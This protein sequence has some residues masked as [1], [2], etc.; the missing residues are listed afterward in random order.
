MRT[1]GG[2]LGE[3]SKEAKEVFPKDFLKILLKEPKEDFLIF[4]KDSEELSKIISE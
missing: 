4:F 2:I 1:T 3:I